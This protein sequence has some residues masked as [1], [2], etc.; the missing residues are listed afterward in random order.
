MRN[1]LLFADRSIVGATTIL[2]GSVDCDPNNGLMIL[3]KG[4]IEFT[5]LIKHSD[6]DENGLNPTEFDDDSFIV[7]VTGS[8]IRINPGGNK[9]NIYAVTSGDTDVIA[10][11]YPRKV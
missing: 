11:V 7:G 3:A 10:R 8:V 6:V 5:I 9:I 1:R 2:L 4:D